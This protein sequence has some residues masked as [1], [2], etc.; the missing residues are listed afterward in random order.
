MVTFTHN[1]AGTSEADWDASG[2]R[3]LPELPLGAE[4]LA[5]MTFVVL[6]AHPDDESLGAGGLLAR[7]HALGA[8]VRLLLCTA[9]EA[10]HPES[11]TT[12]PEQL[13]AV[14]LT[15]FGEAVSGLAPSAKWRFVEVPDGRVAAHVDSVA[16]AIRREVAGSGAPAHRVVLVAPYRSDGHTDHDAL[17]STAA[18]IAA[19][20][21]YGLLEY[22]IWYWLWAGPEDGT[23]ESWVRLPLGPDERR[24]KAQAMH[25]H[26]SQTQPL[27]QEPGD[28]TLLSPTFLEHFSRSWETFAW[29]PPAGGSNTA[30]DAESIFDAV[31]AREEDP[32]D[33]ALGWY[34]RRK[35]ALTL[36]ALPEERYES[37]LEI[38]CSIGVL[39]AELAPRCERFLAVDASSTALAQAARRLSGIG[40]AGTGHLTVPSEWPSGTFDLVVVSEMGYYLSPDELDGMLHRVKDS[41]R[42]GGTLLLCHWRHPISG[43][44]LDGET[45]HRTARRVLD[46]PSRGLYREKDFLLEVLVAPGG[47]A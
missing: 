13:A 9:G 46:W 8:T 21:G 4:E 30:R 47:A 24:A 27:S 39:S 14:R 42:P 37:G 2:V 11:T 18:R 23:W 26:A 15:E 44:T 38:G 22:P 28:E 1:D 10:S 33:Y 3:E 5:S 40:H 35:R 34:E 36:A 16:A 12:T 41:M 45:V 19:A 43:W 6:A 29:T 7:L 32:W 17:G 31:H 25:S 20:E